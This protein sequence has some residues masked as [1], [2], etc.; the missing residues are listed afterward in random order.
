MYIDLNELSPDE[1][2]FNL[3]QT[4]IPRPIAWVL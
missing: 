2:Y 1:V 4:V 3:I